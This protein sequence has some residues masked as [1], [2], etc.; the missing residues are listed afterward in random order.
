MQPVIRSEV[1]IRLAHLRNRDL[2]GAAFPD[3][4][5]LQK[6][7]SSTFDPHKSVVISIPDPDQ[8]LV[9]REWLVEHDARVQMFCRCDW[10]DL[11]IRINRRD[12]GI[13]FA[14]TDQ[15]LAVLFRLRF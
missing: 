13:R 5:S 14:F 3:Y 4:L 8:A 10:V 6:H 15:D 12:R 9:I 2:Y 11:G 7:Q 1:P